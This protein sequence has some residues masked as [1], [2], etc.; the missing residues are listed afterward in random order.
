MKLLKTIATAAFISTSL[1]AAM[2]A[3]A[4]WGAAKMPTYQQLESDSYQLS[5]KQMNKIYTSEGWQHFFSLPGGRAYKV[6]LVDCQM[7]KCTYYSRETDEQQK[8]KYVSVSQVNCSSKKHRS[9]LVA[10]GGKWSQWSSIIFTGSNAGGD[11][12]AFN[13]FCR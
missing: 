11:E 3:R 8:D 5:Q 7:G 2:P 1:F 10:Q 6:K 4:F 9:K 13:M 12:K